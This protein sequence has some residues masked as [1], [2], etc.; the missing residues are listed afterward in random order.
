MEG[1]AISDGVGIWN[2]ANSRR[3]RLFASK[4]SSGCSRLFLV[5]GPVK[6]GRSAAGVRIKKR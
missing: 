6:L 1:V 3:M 4:G 2:F 5:A